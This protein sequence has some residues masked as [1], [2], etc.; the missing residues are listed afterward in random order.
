MAKVREH[1]E[2]ATS[3][4]GLVFYGGQASDLGPLF[5]EPTVLTGVTQD[6]QVAHDETFGP[7]APLFR[8]SD[9]DEVI[10]LGGALLGCLMGIG[11]GSF[12][13][14][15][16]SLYN[17]PIHRAVATAAA[18]AAVPAAVPVAAPVPAPAAAR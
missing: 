14:P 10:A 12:G 4:G 5:F 7:V 8:F 2:D 1:I 15:L 6:M 9:V 18:P 17:T 13:V 11:G 3:K 16:M